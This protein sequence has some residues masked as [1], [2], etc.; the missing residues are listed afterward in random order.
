MYVDVEEHFQFQNKLALSIFTRNKS[1]LH[2]MKKIIDVKVQKKY[3]LA[4]LREKYQTTFVKVH[5]PPENSR[6]VT[7]DKPTKYKRSPLY[8]WYFCI[9][10]QKD[11]TNL[12]LDN[13]SLINEVRLE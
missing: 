13:I 9:I 6:K 3:Y 8:V 12:G 2:L 7:F 11:E 5:K 10:N 4:I 1:V